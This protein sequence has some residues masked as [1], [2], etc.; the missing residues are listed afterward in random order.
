MLTA[1]VLSFSHG[2][3]DVSNAAAPYAAIVAVA[4]SGRLDSAS[5]TPAWVL[6]AGGLGIVLGLA[7]YG[8]RVMATVGTGITRLT[9]S[10]GFAAQLATALTSLAATAL[11]LTVSTTH[12]MIGAITGVAL[13]D[14]GSK[15]NTDLLR[16]IAA[17]WI[18]TLP[19]SAVLAVIA[20]LAFS[21]AG[22][23]SAPPA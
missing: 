4:S 16:K 18:I 1:C 13:A 9:F 2:S 3:Q 12:V 17:S 19:A 22:L 6:A 20:Q 11:G 23:P 15:L 5:T 14:G 21:S 10:K 7:S 8:Y